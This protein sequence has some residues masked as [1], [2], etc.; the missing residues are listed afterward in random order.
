LMEGFGLPAIEAAACGC[1]VIATRESP[2]PELLGEGGI[3]IDPQDRSEL[4][5]ALQEVLDSQA[6]RQFM[7]AKG[8]EAASKLTWEYAAQ[9]MIDVFHGLFQER[10]GR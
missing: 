9:Q 10:A 3:Y 4:T 7:R 5:S 8:L 1:P 2:L 6:L